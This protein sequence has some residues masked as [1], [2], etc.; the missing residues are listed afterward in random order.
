[1]YLATKCIDRS[2]PF[3]SMHVS[4]LRIPAVKALARLGDKNQ[5]VMDTKKAW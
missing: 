4:I 1:M 3:I 5:K 2:E